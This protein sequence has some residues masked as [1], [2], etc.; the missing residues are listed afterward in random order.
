MSSVLRKFWLIAGP[1]YGAVARI[2]IFLG[3]GECARATSLGG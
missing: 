1:V 2:A 3:F